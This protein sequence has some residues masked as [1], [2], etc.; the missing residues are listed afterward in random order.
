M[1]ADYKIGDLIYDANI[2]VGVCMIVGGVIL[3]AWKISL[4]KVTMINISYIGMGASLFLSGLLPASSIILFVILFG[5]FGFFALFQSSPLTVLIQAYIE[6]S[7]LG[8]VFSVGALNALPTLSFLIIGYI[9]D[10]IGMTQTF[11]L[12]WIL[13]L[14]M[15]IISFSIPSIA[16]TKK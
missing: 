4:R 13:I 14:L 6:P 16:Q 3:T 1:N 10:T 2:Y 7:K 5:I 9:A 11:S 12:F 8:R 15:G